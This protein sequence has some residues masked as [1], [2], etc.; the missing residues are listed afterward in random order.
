MNNYSTK[1]SNKDTPSSLFGSSEK[2]QK[3]MATINE[4]IFESQHNSSIKMTRNNEDLKDVT[5]V[6]T[7]N[8]KSF[9]D[10]SSLSNINTDNKEFSW[11]K[12]YRSPVNIK[13]NCKDNKK[14]IKHSKLSKIDY[15]N[16]TKTL[17]NS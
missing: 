11:S 15:A 10:F 5:D 7:A 13:S 2:K 9:S 14:E 6:R 8:K 4:D 16:L 12:T 17:Q 3:F 1:N